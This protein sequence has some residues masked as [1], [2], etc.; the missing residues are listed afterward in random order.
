MS[1]AGERSEVVNSSRVRLTNNTASE[2][3]K[4]MYNTVLFINSN[5]T[6]RQLS[7][8]VLEKFFDLRDFALEAD[9]IIT[10]P[11]IPTWVTRTVQTSNNPPAE[12]YSFD[13][14]DKAS[15]TTT[16]SGTFRL[17]QLNHNIP[18]RGLGNYH[19]RLES[20]DGV[21]TVT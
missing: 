5:V 17:S 11:E 8:D 21:V 6:I 9:I 1:A 12:S 16:L 14:T 7:N 20:V 19:I 15:N 13:F 2:F 4:Q 3:Y 10:E 18:D